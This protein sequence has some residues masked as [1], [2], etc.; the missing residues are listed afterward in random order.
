MTIKSLD[1][2]EEALQQHNDFR[3]VHDAPAMSLSSSLNSG[4]DR[5]A[6]RL[7]DELRC[8]GRLKHSD[9]NSRPGVGENLASGWTTASGAGV[10]GRTVQDAVKAWYVRE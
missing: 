3:A 10:E 1:Y 6:R 4:A 2:R 9:K 5:Y 7:F 8:Y